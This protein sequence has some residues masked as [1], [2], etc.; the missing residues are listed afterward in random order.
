M[1]RN[2]YTYHVFRLK[3]L[4][5]LYYTKKWLGNH[6]F[7]DYIGTSPR[8]KTK[9]K[10]ETTQNVDVDPDDLAL[11]EVYYSKSKIY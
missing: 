1:M 3:D 8:G 9:K 11:D 5:T 7:S 6:H 10:D 4:D 2:L